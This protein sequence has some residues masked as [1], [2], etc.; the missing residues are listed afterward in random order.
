MIA[1]EGEIPGWYYTDKYGYILGP[2]KGPF[3]EDEKQ[4][5]ISQRKGN[6]YD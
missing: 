2:F 6:K 1:K 3:Y 5:Y 4:S